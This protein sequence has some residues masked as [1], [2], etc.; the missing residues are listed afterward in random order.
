MTIW[1]ILPSL[2]LAA[3]T[4]G[5]PRAAIS[6]ISESAVRVQATGGH[7]SLEVTRAAQEGCDHYGRLA[8]YVS[9]RCLDAAC[10]RTET[11]FACTAIEPSHDA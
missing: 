7:L 4:A 8:E 11:L 10:L 1:R 5:E 6:D 3:C 9:H 2:A